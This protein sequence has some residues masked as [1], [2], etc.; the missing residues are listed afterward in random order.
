ML[1]RYQQ[2]LNKDS[3]QEDGVS[4]DEEEEDKEEDAKD[5]NYEEESRLT[6]NM[7]AAMEKL[8][9]SLLDGDQNKDNDEDFGDAI[10]REDSINPYL[11]DMGG[12][13]FSDNDL[14]VH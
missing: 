14:S 5:Q 4:G 12:E 2:K 6:K 3:T 7:N 10:D 13:D 1:T 9:L 11:E 8:N